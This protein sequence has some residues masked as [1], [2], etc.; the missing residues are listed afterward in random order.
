MINQPSPLNKLVIHNYLI[1]YSKLII[2][3]WGLK[4]PE[5]YDIMSA[6]LR[7]SQVVRQRTLNPSS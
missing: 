2:Y 1:F 6:L 7:S 3:L 5:Y 4:Y